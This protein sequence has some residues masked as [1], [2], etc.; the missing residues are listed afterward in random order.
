MI[1]IHITRST[2]ARMTSLR[3]DAGANVAASTI[4]ADISISPGVALR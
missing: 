4:L 1:T 3:I 2:T